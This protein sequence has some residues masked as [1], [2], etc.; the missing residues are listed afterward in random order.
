MFL[1]WNP[2]PQYYTQTPRFCPSPELRNT[3]GFV[4]RQTTEYIYIYLFIYLYLYTVY[5]YNI[6]VAGVLTRGCCFYYHMELTI[7]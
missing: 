5:I 7:Q 3:R 4:R 1:L 6:Y 2:I